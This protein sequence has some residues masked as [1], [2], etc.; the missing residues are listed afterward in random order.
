MNTNEFYQSRRK[1]WELLGKL[2]E[3]G[4]NDVSRLSPQDIEK[5]ASLYRAA[6]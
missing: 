5:L 4:K 2:V 3:K 6:S 1:E